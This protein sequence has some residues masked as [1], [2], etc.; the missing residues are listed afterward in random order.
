MSDN[1]SKRTTIDRY[2]VSALQNGTYKQEKR[3]AIIVSNL[4]HSFSAFR[5]H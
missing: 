5:L 3:S 2:D 1:I 4:Y